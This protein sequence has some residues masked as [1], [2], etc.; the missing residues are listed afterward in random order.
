M[1]S[2]SSYI[3]FCKITICFSLLLHYLHVLHAID[4]TVDSF[5][6]IDSSDEEQSA[7]DQ[8]WIS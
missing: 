2:D 7:L 8:D 5:E 6:S 4:S 1:S 3:L